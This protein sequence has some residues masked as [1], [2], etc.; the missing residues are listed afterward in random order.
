[1]RILLVSHQ[2]DYSGAPLALLQ[3]A[4]T[5]RELGH[6]VTL[7]SLQSG[8]LGRD[9]AA[10]GVQPL[11]AGGA[12]RT[13]FDLYIPNTVVSVPAALRI[14]P[15]PER[16]LA[17]IHE[18]AYF[19]AILGRDPLSFGLDKL[20]HAA[21]PSRFQLLEFEQWMPRCAKHQLPNCI[22]MP[23]PAGAHDAADYVVCSGGWERRKGQER[24]LRLLAAVAPSQPV[25]FLGAG[26][27]DHVSSRHLLFS[28]QVPPAEARALVGRSRGLIS[29]AESETQN[30]TAIEAM[31]AQRPVL[32]SDIPAHRELK[33]Q[34]PAILLYDP[35]D[36]ESFA[37]GWAAFLGQRDDRAA[38]ERMELS[39]RRLFDRA[40]FRGH[41][42][43]LLERVAAG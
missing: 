19:F 40:A 17:W 14:A 25:L 3:L 2:L 9:F 20:R 38:I 29:A 41:V 1:V 22:E 6:E 37:S 34:I 39:A 36:I 11:A 26:K 15:A 32:L 28:G 35:R 31:L 23:P 13:Q 42:A 10:L 8:P 27:P 43:R 21:F 12:G 7:T 4:R 33:E 18:A 16:V 30:L 5:L 24:L